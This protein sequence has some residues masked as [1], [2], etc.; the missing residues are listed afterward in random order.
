MLGVMK[1]LPHRAPALVATALL[2]AAARIGA[3]AV[4]V[5]E[6]VT[7]PKIG[8]RPGAP[9][10]IPA[11]PGGFTTRVNGP[12]SSS[13]GVSGSGSS[14][15]GITSRPKTQEKTVRTITYVA[16]SEP[17]QWQSA[18]GKSLLGKLIAF[19][20]MTVEVKLAPGQ[21]PQPAA[22]PAIPD[23]PTVV[24]DGKARLLVDTK[25]FEVLL[26][27]LSEEDQKFIENIRAAIA[28]ATAKKP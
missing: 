20:D 4:P 24:R 6:K 12:G 8:G 27:R 28:A 14:G 17:R 10:V 7:P 23:K 19:E 2:L 21:Q 15:L 11:T 3:Q 25:P 1:A 18:D 16:L 5:P 9:V 13:L 22:P 26:T